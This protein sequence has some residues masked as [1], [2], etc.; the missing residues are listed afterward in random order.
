M[1]NKPLLDNV[2]LWDWRAFHDTVTQLQ[3]L[4]QYYVFAD[5]DVDRYMIDGQLTSGDAHATR[6]GHPPVAGR[7]HELD[8]R[9]LHLHARVRP[10]N[11]RGEPHHRER[12]AGVSRRGCAADASRPQSLKLTRPEIYYGEVTHEPVFVRTQQPEFNYPSGSENV[13]T[14]YD[15]KGGIPIAGFGMRL[16]AAL[17]YT[18][19]NLLLTR[20]LTPESRMMINR[21]VRERVSKLADFI[22]WDTD[23]Y[24]V[25]TDEGRLVWMIDGYHHIRRDIPIHAALRMGA[26]G[27]VQLHSQLGESDG[28]RL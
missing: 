26:I 5:T 28:R 24:L 4:R 22:E 10:G 8:Q 21:N 7:A 11:G 16:A 14:R 27:S 1:K 2:R 6:T 15:G 25:V 18:D 3:A 12:S 20:Y 19:R 9:T 13:Q 17:A 23:P